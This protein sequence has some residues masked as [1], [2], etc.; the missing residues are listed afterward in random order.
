MNVGLTQPLV[1]NTE[2]PKTC[3]LSIPK[4]GKIIIEPKGTLVVNGGEIHNSCGDLWEGIEIKSKKKNVGKV[5]FI[6]KVEINN[7]ES[8]V[9]QTKP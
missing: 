8:H 6:N 2:L 7:L 1:G 5:V 3:R 9:L 4:G